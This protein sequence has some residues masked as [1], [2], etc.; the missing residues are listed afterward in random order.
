MFFVEIS[1]VV[2]IPLLCYLS[3]F[4]K[5]KNMVPAVKTPLSTLLLY[6]VIPRNH[7]KE[8]ILT[9]MRH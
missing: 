8:Q 2:P 4:Q 3:H 6:V 9:E 7:L 5:T 1:S